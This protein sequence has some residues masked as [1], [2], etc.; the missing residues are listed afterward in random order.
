MNFTSKSVQLNTLTYSPTNENSSGF[1]LEKLIPLLTPKLNS[2]V[3]IT[4][5]CFSIYL[6]L[7][8]K[9]FESVFALFKIA[10]SF[11]LVA[12]KTSLFKTFAFEFSRII[13][14]LSLKG[15]VPSSLLCPVI[16]KFPSVCR[17]FS[18]TTL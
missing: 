14:F 15:F 3:S 18:Y 2:C 6:N 5:A 12:D 4:S 7:S 17:Y 1:V 11:Q 16:V 13:F 9:I 10:S 8:I